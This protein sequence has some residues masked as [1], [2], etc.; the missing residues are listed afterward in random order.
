MSA[1]TGPAATGAAVVLDPAT[2]PAGREASELS[3]ERQAPSATE[4]TPAAPRNRSAW[5]LLISC[6]VTAASVSVLGLVE[7]A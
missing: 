7:P 6:A 2:V 1:L 3:D 5:R 4:L